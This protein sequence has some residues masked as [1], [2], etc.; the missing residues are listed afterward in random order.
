MLDASYLKESITLSDVVKQ[1]VTLKPSGSGRKRW[2]GLCPFHKEKTPSF[3][4]S[5]DPGFYKCF[6]CGNG[7]DV[8]VFIQ[9]IE[10]VDFKTALAQC[11]VIAGIKDEY[12]TP[13]QRRAYDAMMQKKAA[14]SASFRRWRK[15]LTDSLI[16]Y[17]NAVW[18]MYRK[19]RRSGSEGDEFFAEAAA[20]EK[21]LNDL[22]SL[23]ERELMEYYTTQRSWVG[24][25]NPNWYL[26]G[27]RKQVADEERVRANAK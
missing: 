8:F 26:T 23:P 20:K 24:V 16:Y 12:F 27:K 3:C 14:Q 13:E 10:G 19:S 9:Q 6:G 21:A 5:D 18:R 17:T 11:K 7:G 4:V 1:Y 25:M 2:V 15:D 22:E